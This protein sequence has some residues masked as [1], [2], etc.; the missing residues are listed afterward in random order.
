MNMRLTIFAFL[1]PVLE[2]P[3]GPGASVVRAEA[4]HRYARESRD[5]E[6]GEAARG[7]NP[8]GFDVQCIAGEPLPVFPERCRGTSSALK[9]V[10]GWSCFVHHVG[11]KIRQALL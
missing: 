7:G 4:Y 11:E 6:V 5:V 8:R 3:T 9:D 2:S 1:M 10:S